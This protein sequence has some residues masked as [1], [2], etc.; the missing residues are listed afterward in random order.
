MA[1]VAAS[2]GVDIAA[3]VDLLVEP[4]VSRVEAAVHRVPSRERAGEGNRTPVF[5]LG[6]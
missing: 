4:L 2:A 1:D 6:S 3:V 5:S